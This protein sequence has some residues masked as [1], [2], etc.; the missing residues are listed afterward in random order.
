MESLPVKHDPWSYM[1]CRWHVTEI[2]TSESFLEM[3]ARADVSLSGFFALKNVA[4]K[5]VS[6]SGREDLNL[7][8]R[9]PKPRA[10]PS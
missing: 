9:G 4:V 3:F 2:V 8:P 10:L 1:F 7:R 6:W 5:H